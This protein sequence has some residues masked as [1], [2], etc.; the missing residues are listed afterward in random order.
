[1]KP[2]MKLCGY[3]RYSKPLHLFH[4]VKAPYCMECNTEA[5]RKARYLRLAKAD[6]AKLREQIRAAQIQLYNMQEALQTIHPAI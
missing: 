1:M 4:S 2:K 3:C 5:N 6:P